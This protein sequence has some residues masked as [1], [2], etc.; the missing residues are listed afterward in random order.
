MSVLKDVLKEDVTGRRGPACRLSIFLRTV[1]PRDA[2]DFYRAI[3]D[4]TVQAT[5]VWRVL[6]K[7]GYPSSAFTIRYHRAFPPCLCCRALLAEIRDGKKNGKG[8]G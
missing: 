3:A 8:R 7:R 6:K 1:P 4:R 5:S 2:L